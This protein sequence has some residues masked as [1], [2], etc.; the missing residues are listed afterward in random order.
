MP[1]ILRSP[2]EWTRVV[3]GLLLLQQS[4]AKSSGVRHVPNVHAI[5]GCMRRAGIAEMSLYRWG[6]VSV[7]WNT[8]CNPSSR[9]RCNITPQLFLWCLQCKYFLCPLNVQLQKIRWDSRIS[10]GGYIR[11][12]RMSY[13]ASVSARCFDTGFHQ[14]PQITCE[15]AARLKATQDRSDVVSVSFC[16]HRGY[17]SLIAGL[18]LGVRVTG[19]S[20]GGQCDSWLRVRGKLCWFTRNGLVHANR[21]KQNSRQ[22]AT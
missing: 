11:T 5:E 6:Q 8:W 19:A 7:K 16:N 15:T 10:P 2:A 4:L 21:R 13:S 17:F 18:Q 14:N 9:S 1:L 20:S 12:W 3:R 22:N